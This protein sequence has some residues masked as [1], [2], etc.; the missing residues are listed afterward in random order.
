MLLDVCRFV[1]N[2]L[3]SHLLVSSR[4][5]RFALIVVGVGLILAGSFVRK[6]RP[7]SHTQ[8]LHY[9]HTKEITN[10]VTVLPARKTHSSREPRGWAPHFHPETTDSDSIGQS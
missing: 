6:L 1:A 3:V 8:N 7:R 9:P 5:E 4:S 2:G 10:T